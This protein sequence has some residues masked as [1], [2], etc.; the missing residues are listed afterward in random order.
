VRR[1]GEEETVLEALG[2]ISRTA[3]VN[4]ESIAYFELLAGAAWWPRRG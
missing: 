2:Q 1:R 3:R 4:C